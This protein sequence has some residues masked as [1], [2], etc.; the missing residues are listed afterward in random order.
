MTR[1]MN[2]RYYVYVWIDDAPYYVGKGTNKRA[3][4]KQRSWGKMRPNTKVII[5]RDK[6][7]E[8][9]ALR[10]EGILITKWGRKEL[11]K[12]GILENKA[13]ADAQWPLFIS[14][15]GCSP[16]ARRKISIAMKKHY[17]NPENVKIMAEAVRK[18]Y[19]EGKITKSINFYL[20]DPEYQERHRQATIDAMKRPEVRKKCSDAGKRGN[21]IKKAKKRKGQ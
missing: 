5:F 7:N 19:N 18:A 14:K 10:I 21:E 2:K 17:S 8:R 13:P 15:Q 1:N 11:D 12:G 16:E 6:L 4:Q 20:N 9:Q 3:W